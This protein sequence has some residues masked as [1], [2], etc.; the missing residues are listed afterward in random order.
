M[1]FQLFLKPIAHDKQE[2]HDYIKYPDRL[3]GKKVSQRWA[4]DSGEKVLWKG[5]V[6][7]RENGEYCLKYEGDDK[8][9]F[10]TTDEL[11][12]DMV[13]GELKLILA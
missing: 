1:L 3:V 6:Q 10:L 12:S 4:N 8:R 11:L 2:W 7:S 9:Y 13:T 5:A